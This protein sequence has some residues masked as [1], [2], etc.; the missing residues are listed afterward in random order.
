MYWMNNE[1]LLCGEE[2]KS[3]NRSY[4]T[5]NQQLLF[6]LQQEVLYL[7]PLSPSFR[8]IRAA[9]ESKIV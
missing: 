1:W 9:C 5:C 2:I 6:L 3:N 8:L 4:F 7:P